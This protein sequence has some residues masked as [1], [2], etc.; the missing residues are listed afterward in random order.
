MSPSCS[1]VHASYRAK[2]PSISTWLSRMGGHTPT[3]SRAMTKL[4]GAPTR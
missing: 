1:C 3:A 2:A 4:N